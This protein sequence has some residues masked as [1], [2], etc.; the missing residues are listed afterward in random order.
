MLVSAAG[1]SRNRRNPSAPVILQKSMQ[2]PFLSQSP[3]RVG[4][5]PAGPPTSRGRAAS[6][7]GMTG[8]VG[9]AAGARLG[10][11]SGSALDSAVFCIWCTIVPDLEPWDHRKP[12]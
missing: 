11:L 10:T 6:S 12:L 9:E 3:Y 2:R 7:D 1:D 4:S 8:L 5:G